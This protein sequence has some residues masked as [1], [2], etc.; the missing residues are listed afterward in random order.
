MLRAMTSTSTNPSPLQTACRLIGS[1][2]AIG[3]LFDPP[4]SAQAIAKWHDAGVPSERVLRLAEATKFEVKPHE[5]RPDLYP[6]PDDGL[7]PDMRGAADRA[8][9]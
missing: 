1:Y 5:L 9:A 3:A 8:A 6:H 4:V 7:P 2:S